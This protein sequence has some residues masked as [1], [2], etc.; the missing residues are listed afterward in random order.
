MKKFAKT[1]DADD[2]KVAL[3]DAKNLGEEMFFKKYASKS[4]VKK[5]QKISLNDLPEALKES[6]RDLEAEEQRLT[7]Q[8]AAVRDKRAKYQK[9]LPGLEAAG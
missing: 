4:R 7:Q 1:P 5:T 8:L 6:L 3:Q 2:F 9:V